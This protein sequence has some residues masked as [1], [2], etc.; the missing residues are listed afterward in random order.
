MLRLRGCFD[1]ENLKQKITE[2]EKR[3]QEPDF[4]QKNQS[5]QEIFEKL[6][7][8]KKQFEDFHTV[9]KSLE[10]LKELEKLDLGAGDK[11]LIQEEIQK[12]TPKIEALE[13]MA[14]FQDEYDEAGAILS[15]SAGTGGIDAQDWAEML[16]RMYLRYLEKSGFKV[17]IVSKNSGSEAGIKN[18]TLLVSTAFA[19]GNLKS[20]NGVHRLVRISPFSS[21]ASRETSF[22]LVE[23]IPIFKDLEN[24]EI[25]DQDLRIESFR[26]SG[27]GGQSVNTTDSAIRITHKPTGIAVTCQNERSQ[28]QNKTTALTILKAKLEQMQ[29]LE[30]QK[31]LNQIK[32]KTQAAWGNQVRSYVLQPYTLVKDHRTGYTTSDVKKVLA[33]E[34]DEFIKSYLIYNKNLK[35]KN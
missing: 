35:A 29:K 31:T 23:I 26:A 16:L 32:G 34:I 10:E 11:N 9:K 33:G 27:H 15:L 22:A 21:G 24:F 18:A 8:F 19:Y 2:I 12:I 17:Q 14:Y 3:T 20:E 5:S 1:L 25:Q 30:K 28:L 13:K 7:T 4:W 6:A